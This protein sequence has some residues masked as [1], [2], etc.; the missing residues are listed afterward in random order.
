MGDDPSCP[1]TLVHAVPSACSSCLQQAILAQRFNVTVWF[2]T[3]ASHSILALSFSGRA[4]LGVLWHCQGWPGGQPECPAE[5]S[6][7]FQLGSCTQQNGRGGMNIGAGASNRLGQSLCLCP[8]VLKRQVLGAA[9]DPRK[10]CSRSLFL[11]L[12][13]LLNTFLSVCP[14]KPE[15]ALLMPSLSMWLWPPQV[16][17][18]I[19][20]MRLHFELPLDHPQPTQQIFQIG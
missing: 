14:L 13:G 15:S 18:I 3:L 6:E 11:P 4:S 7:S 20:L 2:L 8:L 10:E 1:R 16:V 17:A 5:G 9:Y 19:Q 12:P